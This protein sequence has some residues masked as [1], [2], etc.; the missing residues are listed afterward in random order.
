MYL[1]LLTHGAFGSFTPEIKR[2]DCSD[3]D[4]NLCL[5]VRFETETDIAELDQKF[6][7]DFSNYEGYFMNS[8]ARVFASTPEF[9]NRMISGN[10]KIDVSFFQWNY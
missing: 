1:G 4:S 7:G 8:G 10:T 2:V 6:E 9:N 3:E 5:E